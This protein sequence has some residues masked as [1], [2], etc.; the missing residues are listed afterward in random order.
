M[1]TSVDVPPAAT[2]RNA[3]DFD[4]ASDDVFARI[5]TR[6]DRLCD[7]FSLFIHRRWKSHMAAIIAAQPAGVLLDVASGTGDIPLRV[8]RK[9]GHS[10]KGD[11][12]T[13]WVTDLCPQ[14][15][16]MAKRKLANDVT[17]Q[18]ARMNTHDLNELSAASV[19]MFSIS[20][21]M[22]ICD[23]A[24]VVSEAFRVL[25]P[26]GTFYCLEAARIPFAPL[27]WLYLRYMDWCLPLI[28][29]VAVSDRSAYDY[30]L[31]GIH[32]FPTQGE[33]ADELRTA[34]FGDVSFE[35]L[36]FG[37]VA[38]HRGTKPD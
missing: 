25:K 36:T 16:E 7:I 23:R 3:A 5:A 24:K 26:G 31:R 17:V 18:F 12:V 2:T 34:G 28:A 15:L 33:F 38:L 20:F 22:K 27:H 6:Y 13:L 21:G 8:L 35:N 4:P 11:D 14:M 30:L 19:D 9:R 1:S 29:R 37:I 10:K 32:E